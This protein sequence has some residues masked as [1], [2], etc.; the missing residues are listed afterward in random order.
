MSMP[1]FELNSS[2]LQQMSNGMPGNYVQ[3]GGGQGGMMGF[4]IPGQQ[5]GSQQGQGQQQQQQ[6]QTIAFPFPGMSGGM[7]SPYG[8]MMGGQ[9][10]F[11]SMGGMPPG[12]MV[13]MPQQGKMN[14]QTKAAVTAE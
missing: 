1:S 12:M 9:N 4:M 13:A 8:A 11:F 3:M 14:D 2:M 7:P 5:Q 6:P 10:P